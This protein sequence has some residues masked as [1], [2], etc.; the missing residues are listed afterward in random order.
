LQTSTGQQRTD[1]ITGLGL[2]RACAAVGASVAAI[3]AAR[4]SVSARRRGKRLAVGG[5]KTMGLAH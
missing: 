4:S 1:V 2:L 3:S 5:L